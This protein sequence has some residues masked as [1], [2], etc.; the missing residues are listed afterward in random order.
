MDLVQSLEGAETGPSKC[1]WAEGWAQARSWEGV[2]RPQLTQ[3]RLCSLQS[4]VCGSPKRPSQNTDQKGT[5]LPGGPGTQPR[6]PKSVSGVVTA[7]PSRGC[8]GH[9]V[10]VRFTGIER[11]AAPSLGRV[12]LFATP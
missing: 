9:R 3:P 1:L 8:R 12:Q 6:W 4:G 10:L 5:L 2:C 7:F 11:V